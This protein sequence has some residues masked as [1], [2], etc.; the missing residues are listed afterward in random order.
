MAETFVGWRY[1]AW[2]AFVIG[3]IEVLAA[4]ALFVPRLAFYAAALLVVIMLGAL[5]TVIANASDLG[6]A[7]AG[8]QVAVMSVIAA[9]RFPRRM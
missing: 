7:T 1:P 6:W 5:Y 8:T 3:T 9:L 4:I 2:F